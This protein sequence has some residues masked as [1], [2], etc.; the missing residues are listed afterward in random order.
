MKDITWSELVREIWGQSTSDKDIEILLY[1]CTCFPFGTAKQVIQQLKEI[2]DRS[3]RDISIAERLV[4][5]DVER[6]MRQRDE[7]AE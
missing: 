5:K 7:K 2:R 1:E 3:G 4:K 6:A